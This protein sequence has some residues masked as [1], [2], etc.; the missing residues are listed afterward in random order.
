[1]ES[2]ESFIL[3]LCL[4]VKNITPIFSYRAKKMK[5]IRSYEYLIILHPRFI[6]I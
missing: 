2:G 1:M 3:Y 6:C 4:L 5:S